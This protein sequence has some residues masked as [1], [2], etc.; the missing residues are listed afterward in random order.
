MVA[1]I[2][3][4]R[5]LWK[6]PHFHLTFAYRLL[7][8]WNLKCLRQCFHRLGSPGSRPLEGA[9]NAY[10]LLASTL[11]RAQQGSSTEQRSPAGDGPV[12]SSQHHREFRGYNGS[13]GCFKLEQEGQGIILSH[14]SVIECGPHPEVVEVGVGLENWAGQLSTARQSSRASIALP[15]ARS[16]GLC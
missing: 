13:Q 9:W 1:T 15:M 4:Q 10:L 5:L 16:A 6:Q 2:K 8:G 12:T 11:W 7:R 3:K 14:E